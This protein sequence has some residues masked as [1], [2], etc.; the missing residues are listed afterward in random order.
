MERADSA[1]YYDPISALYF[2]GLN[3]DQGR[4]PQ[5]SF[6]DRLEG[7]T[8]V[9]IADDRMFLFT[10]ADGILVTEST[11]KAASIDEAEDKSMKWYTDH[12][13]QIQRHEYARQALSS[14]I[15]LFR[16]DFPKGFFLSDISATPMLPIK[17]VGLARQDDGWKFTLGSWRR[18]VQCGVPLL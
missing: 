13:T 7:D 8:R 4:Y 5:D 16:A 17:F 6:S 11:E 3:W 2:D 1:S 10:L 14:A 9:G 12:L 15:P 18:T